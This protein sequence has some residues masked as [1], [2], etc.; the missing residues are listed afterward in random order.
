MRWREAMRSRYVQLLVLVFAAAALLRF[1]GLNWDDGQQLHPDERFLFMVEGGIAPVKS[2]AEYLDTSRSTLNPH[3]RGFGFFVY[4]TFPIVVVRYFLE[5]VRGL[6]GSPGATTQRATSA[7]V[8]LVTLLFTFLVARR[9]YGATIGLLAATFYAFAVLPIQL[10]HFFT[11]DPWAACFTTI[12][13]WIALG[14]ARREGALDARDLLK[15]AALF[16]LVAGLACASKIS[17]AIIF[18]ALGIAAIARVWPER[19]LPPRLR[20]VHLSNTLCLA[21]IVALV[22]FRLL[23]PY[24]FTGPGLFGI[25]LNPKWLANIAEVPRLQKPTSGFPPSVQW[26]NRSF[27]YG[28]TNLVVWGLGIPLGVAAW[29]GFGRMAGRVV[30]GGMAWMS[31]KHEETPDDSLAAHA[32]LVAWV[33]VCFGYFGV[34]SVAPMF[35]YQLPVYPVLCTM[36]AWALVRWRERA[37]PRLGRLPAAVTW[38][39]VVV[40]IAWAVGFWRIYQRPMSRVAASRWM[41]QNLPGPLGLLIRSPDGTVYHQPV[42]VPPVA[43]NAATAWSTEV[44]PKRAGELIGVIAHRFLPAGVSVDLAKF[45]LELGPSGAPPRHFAAVGGQENPLG[46]VARFDVQPPL[47]V[48]TG[49]PLRLKL[50]YSSAEAVSLDGVHIGNEAWDDGLPVRVDGYDPYGGIYKGKTFEVA[51]PD[52]PAKRESVLA[53]LAEVD[54]VALSSNRAWASMPRV[55]DKYPIMTAY[56]RELL[57]CPPGESI[58]WCYRVAEPGR[59][60]GRLGFELV[61]SVTSFPSLFGIPVNDQSAEESFTVYDHPKVLLF[62][63]TKQFSPEAAAAVLDKAIAEVKR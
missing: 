25:A 51:W 52:T 57:G 4:G 15:R 42:P 48:E 61:R 44:A 27:L 22:T 32:I 35:R 63:R 14:I 46:A 62:R 18:A 38:G 60:T 20:V 50:I 56:Y 45:A 23:Q 24:A 43:L 34:V 49:R 26:Y 55:P 2:L 21:V 47:A 53:A 19:S 54:Y 40:T 37:A 29:I 36:A 13:L 11:V 59:F 17:V 12:A 58:L 39:V 8:D 28:W 1:T 9:A 41:F 5:A 3:N 31:G 7:L 10:S 30:R 6:G 16:G 33:A